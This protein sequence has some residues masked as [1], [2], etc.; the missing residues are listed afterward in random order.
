MNADADQVESQ[1]STDNIQSC[2]DGGDCCSPTSAG[3]GKKWKT[4]I[5]AVIVLAAG[6]VLANSLVRR[7]SGTSSAGRDQMGY[8]S[9]ELGANSGGSSTTS[10]WKSEL[11]SLAALNTAAADVDGVFILL[12][13]DD[14][15]DSSVITKQIDA[16][17]QTLTSSKF[18]I[19]AFR[20]K[21]TAPEYEQLSKQMSVP[22]VLAM[23]KGGGV[24]P[25]SGQINETR[26]IQAFVAAMRPGSSCGPAGCCP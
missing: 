17:A 26:L 2:C 1:E 24:M 23:T 9:I 5:F 22:C 10:L 6:A 7:S 18:R 16:A 21:Q 25:V 11:D 4:V 3:S 20:L 15:Q 14:Q 13:G 8:A 12:T 19:S